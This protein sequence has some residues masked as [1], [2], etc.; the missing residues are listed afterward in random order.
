LLEIVAERSYVEILEKRNAG[1]RFVASKRTC[2]ARACH[3][4]DFTLR[5]LF[6]GSRVAFLDTSSLSA[7]VAKVIELGST[8]LTAA[9]DVDMVDN[10]CVQ[11]KDSLDADAE[12]NLSDGYRLA[13]AAVLASNADAFECLKPFFIAFLD[14][15][16]YPDGVA[17]LKSRNV[18]LQLRFLNKI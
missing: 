10:G 2:R 18:F 17:G 4:T 12:G 14:P 11:R 6:L 1:R 3:K 7:K 13:R 15:N 8:H 5:S 16:V 9:D